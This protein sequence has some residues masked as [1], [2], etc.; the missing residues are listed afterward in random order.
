MEL[1][2]NTAFIHATFDGGPYDGNRQVLVP[3]WQFVSGANVR[4]SRR[5]QFTLENLYLT[6]QVRVNDTVNA[7]S[8]NLYNVMNARL[9]YRAKRYTAFLA[10]NNLLD[11]TY[12]QAPSTTLPG[13]GP[14]TLAHNPAPGISFQIG[15]KAAF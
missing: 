6:G 2:A 12:E 11:R 5:I 8:R 9:A 10:L 4:V 13:L 7:Q 1:F 15:L 14:Q 3:E